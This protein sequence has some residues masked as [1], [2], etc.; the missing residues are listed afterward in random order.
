MKAV[1]VP[2]LAASD[3]SGKFLLYPEGNG[4]FLG[5]GRW[6]VEEKREPK[7]A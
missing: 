6:R 7:T 5:S 2:T 3:P 4:E 1:P